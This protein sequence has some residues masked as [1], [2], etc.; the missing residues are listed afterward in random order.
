MKYFFLFD[1]GPTCTD[2]QVRAAYHRLIQEYPPEKD[3]QMFQLVQEAATVLRTERDR[4]RYYL[5]H[6]EP[7]LT[8]PVQAL[9]EYSQ[10]PNRRQAPGF[11]A[12]KN[13]ARAAASSVRAK[14][15]TT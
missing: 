8:S 10:L 13:L 7:E 9:G 6:Q 15:P 2:E 4:W 14:Y 12:F 5:F 3:P 11:D 1:L